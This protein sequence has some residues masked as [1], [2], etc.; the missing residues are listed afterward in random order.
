MR[1]KALAEIYTM[2]LKALAEIYLVHNALHCTAFGIHNRK[3]GESGPGHNNSE[4]EK[5]RVDPCQMVFRAN[6]CESTV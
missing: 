2:R 3:V 4:K 5:T 6:R 1:L